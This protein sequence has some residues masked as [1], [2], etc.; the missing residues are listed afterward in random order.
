MTLN[1]DSPLASTSKVL[2]LCKVPMFIDYTVRVGVVRTEV[3]SEKCPD[4]RL[5]ILL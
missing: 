5:S 3:L 1:L 4:L 2:G